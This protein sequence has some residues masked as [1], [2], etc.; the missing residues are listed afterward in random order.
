[1]DWRAKNKFEEFVGT[2]LLLIY[3]VV[4]VPWIWLYDKLKGKQN[5]TK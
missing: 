2:A 5:G 1:M 4:A 3:W